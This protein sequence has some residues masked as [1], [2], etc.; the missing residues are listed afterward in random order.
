[1]TVPALHGPARAAGRALAAAR[2]PAGWRRRMATSLG[3]LQAL[4]RAAAWVDALA[5]LDLRLRRGPLLGETLTALLDGG[6][7][8]AQASG[9]RRAPRPDR[10]PAGGQAQT[11][12]PAEACEPAAG[13]GRMMRDLATVARGA[14]VPPGPVGGLPRRGDLELLERA[15]A[16][17]DPELLER[18]GAAG[19]PGAAAHALTGAH[20][21]APSWSAGRSGRRQSDAAAPPPGQA[22]P[23]V[24]TQWVLAAARRVEA[25]LARGGPAGAMPGQAGPAPTGARRP[26]DARRA[27]QL[28]HRL[29]A[30]WSAPMGGPAAPRGLLERHGG[31]SPV[32]TAAA[33]TARPPQE[34]GGETAAPAAQAAEPGP[35]GRPAAPPPATATQPPGRLSSFQ[36][37]GPGAGARTAASGPDMRAGAPPEGRPGAAGEASAWSWAAAEEEGGTEDGL[38]VLADQIQQILQE[39]SRR[40]GIDV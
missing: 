1:V 14:R 21:P 4:A 12:H 16:A 37:D 2:A 9:P 6:R 22:D 23:P 17:G 10:A 3:R 20:R 35:H 31:W 28:A 30:Q 8:T 13:A 32:P 38:R 24:L 25:E 33:P 15:G 40:H 11:G 27:G 18:A 5:A 19:A 29:A 36:R 34:P 26:A 39:E 7:P